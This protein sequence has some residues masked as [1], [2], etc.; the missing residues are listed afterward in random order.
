MVPGSPTAPLLELDGVSFSRPGRQVLS[1]VSLQIMEG[2]LYSLLGPNGAGKTTLIK[3]ICG[4]IRPAGGHIRLAGEQADTR[5]SRRHIGLVPQALALFSHL[6]PREN[7]QV[8]ARLAGLARREVA[9]AVE[10]GLAAA[11]LEARADDPVHSLSGG[12]QRRV[13]I[14]AAILHRP[15]LLLLDEP[16]VGVDMD[17]RH[18]IHRILRSLRARGMAILLTTHDLEQAEQLSDRV[19][20]LVEGRL[21]QQGT[22]QGLLQQHF[23]GTREL[24]LRLR[25]CPDDGQ[26][27]WLEQQGLTVTADPCLWLGL[28]SQPGSGSQGSLAAG[29]VEDMAARLQAQH[30]EPREVRLRHPD[31]NSLMLRLTGREAAA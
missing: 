30:L 29:G 1:A 17:A 7:L 23:A 21:S 22:P 9:P 24:L 13:N 12:Y 15:R 8:F 19:G 11:L 6:T 25:R 31:L 3:A 14:A 10:Q 16:T 27:R 18:A 26:C 4:R 5:A 20:F 2:E 28:L